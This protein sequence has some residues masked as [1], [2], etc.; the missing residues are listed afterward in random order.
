MAAED[1]TRRL[2]DN[3]RLLVIERRGFRDELERL[4]IRRPKPHQPSQQP[5]SPGSRSRMSRRQLEKKAAYDAGRERAKLLADRMTASKSRLHHAQEAAKANSTKSAA[6]SSESV[7]VAPESDA[8]TRSEIGK[9]KVLLSS[10]F[11]GYA[12]GATQSSSGPAPPCR[13]VAQPNIHYPMLQQALG[14]QVC[15]TGCLHQRADCCTRL[16]FAGPHCS[17]AAVPICVPHPH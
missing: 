8:Q 4:G 13:P 7:G 2:Q 12:A 14:Y 10:R 17:C 5:Q 1:S 16:H 15:N 3:N 9:R 6:P 11:A